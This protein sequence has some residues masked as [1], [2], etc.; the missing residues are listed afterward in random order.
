MDS[1]NPSTFLV[2]LSKLSDY[3][4][5]TIFG[6]LDRLQTIYCEHNAKHSYSIL[7]KGH[8]CTANQYA[9]R[10]LRGLE[11]RLLDKEIIIDS[12]YA[13]AEEDDGNED[14]G[15]TDDTIEKLELIKNDEF[16]RNYVVRWLTGF[17]S[18][19]FTWTC[20]EDGLPDEEIERREALVE[21]AVSLL[22]SCAGSDEDDEAVTRVFK[23]QTNIT[24]E[25]KDNEICVELNDA[26]L[27]SQDH[28][29]VGL[30]SWASAIFLSKMI[31][32]DPLRFGITTDE[33]LRILELG[34]GTG[35][36]SIAVAKLLNNMGSAQATEIVATDYHPDVLSNLRRNVDTNLSPDKLSD[37]MALCVDK[38]DWQYPSTEP[39]FHDSFDVIIGA[40]VIYNENHATW[41]SNCVRSLLK[42][43]SPSCLEG[44][45]FWL[46]IAI[47]TTGRHEGLDS[48]VFDAFPQLGDRQRSNTDPCLKTVNVWDMD[49]SDGIG[50]ADE[51][52]YRLY[53]VCWA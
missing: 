13:S 50:R 8:T 45:V 42:R 16:E 10:Q 27:L 28:S 52:A 51:S 48:T 43:P 53:K 40:D 23:F 29:S 22:S 31:C 1:Y 35:L 6:I 5:A 46:M 34:A 47:R 30:Q 15:D 49:R 21:W 41:L 11:A 19:S 7:T 38:Y 9:V 17:I 14:K 32:Q 26:P 36:V 12:G 24:D 20:P 33:S 2:S 37:H 44:G 39:P 25:F 3:P 18:R 4:T